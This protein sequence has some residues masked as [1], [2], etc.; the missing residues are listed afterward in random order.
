MTLLA[1]IVPPAAASACSTDWIVELI[2]GPK[3]LLYLAVSVAIAPHLF[4]APNKRTIGLHP[5]APC[6]SCAHFVIA[7]KSASSCVAASVLTP[8]TVRDPGIHAI[9]PNPVPAGP[10][11]PP[12]A[13]APPT[14][15]APGAAPG[16]GAGV[17]TGVAATRLPPLSNA[18]TNGS[19]FFQRVPSS[20]ITSVTSIFSIVGFDVVAATRSTQLLNESWLPPRMSILPSIKIP[21]PNDPERSSTASRIGRSNESS[22]SK[23]TRTREAALFETLRKFTH[24]RM[25]PSLLNHVDDRVSRIGL[26]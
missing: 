15:T 24:S 2:S 19:P 12:V 17:P 13:V 18:R 3:A 4:V 14:C 11:V 16:A 20:K 26:D 22:N 8:N 6:A 21:G 9:A 23:A 5:A 1:P 10:T 7:A 25:V